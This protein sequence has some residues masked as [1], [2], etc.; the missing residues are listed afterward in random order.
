MVT[1]TMEQVMNFRNNADFFSNVNLPLK[2][3]YKLNKI[4]QNVNKEGEF[5]AEKFQEIIDKYSKRDENGDYVFSEDGEQILIKEDMLNECN[6]AL[7]DL[8]NLKV[9]IDNQNLLLED[10]GE[11]I[12]CTPEQLE[13]LMPFIN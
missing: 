6:Q 2:G 12:A 10:L 4:R 3:A 7:E 13:A 5:Y 8:M 1:V 9:E 11:N